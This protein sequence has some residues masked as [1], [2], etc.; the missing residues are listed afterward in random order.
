M[1]AEIR[2]EKGRP[3]WGFCRIKAQTI[4]GIWASYR[5]G[6]LKRRDLQTWFAAHELVMR[7][8]TLRRERDARFLIGEIE[9]LTGLN[10]SSVKASIKRLEHLKFLSWST[11]RV[12]V[13]CGSPDFLRGLTGLSEM[14]ESVT[15]N[16]RT[17]P[18]PR[19]TV[20]LLCRV[21]RPVMMATILGLLFRV[22]YY[23]SCECLSWG[24][25]KASFIASVFGVDLRNVKSARLEL[26]RSGWLRSEASHHWHRQRFGGTFVISLEWRLISRGESPPRKEEMTRKSPPPIENRNLPSEFK[27]QN[28]FAGKASGVQG[29]N[30]KREGKPTLRHIVPID[31][32]D[33]LRTECL[34]CEAVE[35][36]LVAGGEMGRLQFFAAAERAK[37][38][39]V[40]PGGFFTAIVSR[41]LWQNASNGDEEAARR[42]LQSLS[43]AIASTGSCPQ[44][45]AQ[46]GTVDAAP[47]QSRS[48]IRELIRS[49]LASA[50]ARFNPTALPQLTPVESWNA[51][52]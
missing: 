39:A 11:E 23:R 46:I 8:C 43:V 10:G 14:L 24:T 42:V 32:A 4:C 33:P 34:Y 47:L 26:E 36:K 3:T 7:R 22:M 13:K 15:N 9:E 5:E 16:R 2:G 45:T 41:K 28:R 49:S 44:R 27:N 38:L 31:L 12:E 17:I 50:D 18:I 25:C 20:L 21:R 52:L 48:D 6:H 19:Q 1:R 51:T 40:K 37:R 30:Q 35:R 29:Q